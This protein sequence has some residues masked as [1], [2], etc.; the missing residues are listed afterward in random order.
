MGLREVFVSSADF[1]KRERMDFAVIGAFSLR[2]FGYTRATRDIDLITRTEHQEKIIAYLTSLG[3]ETIQRTTAFTNHI[4][5]VENTRI[6]IMYVEGV[7]ADKIFTAVW[8][9]LIIEEL[10]FPVVSP[11]HLIALKLFAASNDPKRKFREFADIQQIL[12]RVKTDKKA[13]REYFRKY[14]FEG[15][16]EEII[17]D[18]CR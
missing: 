15:D 10:E 13:V 9:G 7:T 1:F 5:P 6:D 11:E 18:D 16:Y 17:Q 14:G 4:H 3:F 12:Q 8:K 2:A